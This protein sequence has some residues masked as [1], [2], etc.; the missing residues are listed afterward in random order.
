M[1]EQDNIESTDEQHSNIDVT[2]YEGSGDVRLGRTWRSSKGVEQDWFR[3]NEGE[4]DELAELLSTEDDG[5]SDD[6]NDDNGDEYERFDPTDDNVTKLT[7]DNQYDV[8]KYIIEKERTYTIVEQIGD[9]YRHVQFHEKHMENLRDYLDDSDG[10]MGVDHP[11]VMTVEDTDDAVALDCL[12]NVSDATDEQ[13][14]MYRQLASIYEDQ[15]KTVVQ[16]NM[17]YSSSFLQ[18]GV[19][20]ANR[21]GGPFDEPLLA[22]LYKL[23]TR[24]DDKGDRFYEQVF[25]GGN[26]FVGENVSETSGDAMN[27]WALTTWMLLYGGE[28]E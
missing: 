3:I 16:K 11:T 23:W 9:S 13:K 19:R 24:N 17:D 20:D 18:G 6:G 28:D 14:Q 2:R 1:T 12:V 5:G 10:V 26:Y 15:F 22:N 8:N 21:D 27:Y 4:R 25:G 7:P